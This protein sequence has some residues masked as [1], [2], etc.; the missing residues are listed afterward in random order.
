MA[1][2]NSA[3]G[4]SSTKSSSPQSPLD[5]SHSSS[6][7]YPSGSDYYSANDHFQDDASPSSH[8]ETLSDFQRPPYDSHLISPSPRVKTASTPTLF[9]CETQQ[10]DESRNGHDQSLNGCKKDIKIFVEGDK[11]CLTESNAA[12]QDETYIM[13]QVPNGR[14]S[15]RRWL[16]WAKNSKMRKEIQKERGEVTGGVKIQKREKRKR[17]RYAKESRMDGEQNNGMKRRKRDSVIDKENGD[18]EAMLTSSEDEPLG[19]IFSKVF[20]PDMLAAMG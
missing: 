2:N 6:D 18:K 15:R 7:D 9:E 11:E 1:S 13:A 20:V 12:R 4:P 17:D 19:D 16:S 3:S 5:D 8:H 14:V 10:T